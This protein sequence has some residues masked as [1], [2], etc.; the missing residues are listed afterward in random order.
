MKRGYEVSFCQNQTKISGIVLTDL[1]S[2][3]IHKIT[4]VIKAGRSGERH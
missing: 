1:H 3:A 4:Q 2:V